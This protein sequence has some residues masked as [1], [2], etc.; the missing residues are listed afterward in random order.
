VGGNRYLKKRELERGEAS[1][2]KFIS[3]FPFQRGRGIKGDRVK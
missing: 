1:L 2:K 3:P